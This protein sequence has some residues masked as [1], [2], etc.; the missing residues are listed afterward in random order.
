MKK[1]LLSLFLQCSV[2]LFSQHKFLNDPKL[3]DADLMREKSEKYPDAPAE[4]LYRS[5]H[6]RVDYDGYIYKDVVDR[7][8]IYNKDNASQ[9]LDH[10]I[11]LYKNNQGSKVVLSDLKA[12]TYT[13]ENGKR[14]TTKVEKDE[15]YESKEDKNYTITKFAFSNVKNGSVV[16]YSYSLYSPFIGSTP[17]ILIEDEIP[18]KYIEYV[19]DAPKPIGYSLNYKGELTPTFRETGDRIMYG[20]DYNVYRFGYENVPPYKEEKYVLNNDN[21]K[22]GIKAELN[23]TYFGTVFKSYTLSWKDV[24]KRLYENENFGYELKR[25]NLVK[26]LLPASIKEIPLKKDRARAILN[27]VQKN[28]TWNKEDDVVTD[29]GIKNLLSTKIGNTA[30]LNILLILLLRNADIEANPVVLA[31]VKL[32]MLMGYLPSLAQLNFVLASYIE[33][34]RF[35]L[36]DATSKQSDLNMISPRALNYYGYYMPK[37]DA[38]QISIVFPEISKTLL[39]VEAK[40]NPDGTFEGKFSD[41]DTK[42]YGMIEN[43]SFLKDKEKYAKTYKED[44]KFS[45]TNFKQGIQDNGEFESSFDFSADTFTDVLGNKMVFNPLLFLYSQKHNF[46]QKEKRKAPLEFYS[47]SDRIKKVTITIPDNYVF[48]NVPKS[49]KFRTEDNALVY[50]YIVTQEGNKLTVETSMMIDDAVFPAQ[51]YPAFTQIFDNIT[52]MEAQVVTAVKK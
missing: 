49:K 35:V 46:D 42:L 22:T 39:N 17:R 16:E 1:I 37:D 43:E 28:Y 19:F 25:N 14:L 52:K 18:I 31:T 44:Y 38:K 21:Y 40:M 12:F 45:Y 36:L 29:K 10:Q 47:A 7:V 9:Y 27:F 4:V 8:K 11:P 32:G 6:F 50:S 15:K 5:I 51:Y 34:D 2:L 23:S 24:S 48:E 3:S 30:E 13:W 41:R 33:G 20:S 26:D